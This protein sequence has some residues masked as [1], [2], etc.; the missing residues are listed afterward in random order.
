MRFPTPRFASEPFEPSGTECAL[1][2][3]VSNNKLCSVVNMLRGKGA[4]QRDLD[5]LGKWA[6]LSL[7]KLAASE[8]GYSYLASFGA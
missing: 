4:T 1:S 8:V 5:K 2:R 7:M 6:H 3:F